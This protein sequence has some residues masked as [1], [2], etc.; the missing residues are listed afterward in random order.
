MIRTLRLFLLLEGA[1]FVTAAAVHFG[2]LLEGYD[3]GKAGTAET[4]IAVVLVAGLALSWSRPPTARRAA[5]AA[6]AFATLGVI[7][8]LFTIA[9][10]V[11]PRT[12]LDI[13]YHV[14]ILGVL[15]AGLR[16]AVREAAL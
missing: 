9:V 5:A 11:G 4:V 15:L 16:V 2:A 10:G 12:A 3:H 8:G 6:Q 13:A 14:V 7:V 1:S